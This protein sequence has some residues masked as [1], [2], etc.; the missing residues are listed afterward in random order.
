MTLGEKIKEARRNA[1][2]TQETLAEHLMVS[3]PAISKWEAD[4]GMPD[5]ENLKSLSRILGV[6]LDYLL[7][8][9]TPLDLS[10][11]REPIDLAA[12]PK[13]LKKSRK[14][15]LMHDRFPGATIHTLIAERIRSKKD[16]VHDA[17]A[18][19]VFGAPIPDVS[20]G[21]YQFQ[22]IGTEFYLVE[23][24]GHQDFVAVSDE[25]IESHRLATPV[26]T[27]RGGYL[28]Y[29]DYRYLFCGPIKIKEK[30]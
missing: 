11:L 28:Y 13:G 3:R 10:C 18:F 14:D 6:S 17:I 7:D 23:S 27:K 24:E 22:L 4:K 21:V 29:G 26:S 9:G 15:R 30:K 2:M 12:Y 8:D 19:W 5:I 1:G 20:Q 16:K 25:F